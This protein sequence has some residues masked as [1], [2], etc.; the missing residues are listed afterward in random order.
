[1]A[2]SDPQRKAL[3]LLN[4]IVWATTYFIL[5]FGLFGPFILRVYVDFP[6][7]VSVNPAEGCLIKRMPDLFFSE[8]SSGGEAAGGLE[9]FLTTQGA[10]ASGGG[11][12]HRHSEASQLSVFTN[13]GELVLEAAHDTVLVNGHALAPGESLRE[14][15][16][17]HWNPWAVSF[18]E[19]QNVGSIPD[20]PLTPRP[21]G[22]DRP[23]RISGERTV[24]LG[25]YGTRY[26][27][28][29]GFTVLLALTA[30]GIVLRR[31]IR[32]PG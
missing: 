24:V 28:L 29:K 9:V 31:Q 11:C 23:Q 8:D 4:R 18:L 21:A 14:V 6:C 16:Y 2:E 13:F 17:L 3:S 32:V 30:F 20:C 1:M 7:L 10:Y 15:R 19:V 26:S 12:L 22:P 25:A 5:A 27:L